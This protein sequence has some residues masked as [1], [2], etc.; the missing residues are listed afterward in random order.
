MVHSTFECQ[1]YFITRIGVLTLHYYK[2]YSG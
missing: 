2:I 1:G